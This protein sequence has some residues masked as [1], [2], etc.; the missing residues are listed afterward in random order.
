LRAGGIPPFLFG[1]P[2]RAFAFFL[3]EDVFMPAKSK[4]QQ[5]AAG[6]ALAAKRGEVKKSALKGAS[7][8]MADSMSETQLEEFASTKRKGKPNYVSGSPIPAKKAARSK[9]AKKGAATR[10]K[11]AKKKSRR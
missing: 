5:K 2:P 3:V 1:T 4:A 7:R 8:Q 9:A 11:N 10:A 6:A